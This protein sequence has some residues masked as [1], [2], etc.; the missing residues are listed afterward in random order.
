MKKPRY[1]SN[2]QHI[3]IKD[4]FNKN[5]NQYQMDTNSEQSL[6]IDSDAKNETMLN[7][8]VFKD[9]MPLTVVNQRNRINQG[10]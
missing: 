3:K 6:T 7:L 10:L 2:D 8:K 5:T 1:K 4:N 9:F